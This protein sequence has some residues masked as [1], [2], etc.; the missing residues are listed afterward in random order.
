MA[1]D[2][3]KRVDLGYIAIVFIVLCA[4]A[5]CYGSAFAVP[6]FI[7]SSALFV[8]FINKLFPSLA[9]RSEMEQDRTW[10]ASI[11][12]VNS[13]VFGALFWLP[14]S[15]AGFP[16]LGIVF[17]LLASGLL[18]FFASTRMEAMATWA[19]AFAVALLGYFFGACFVSAGFAPWGIGIGC[20]AF[21]VFCH[22][23]V[24]NTVLPSSYNTAV[25]NKRDDFDLSCF[26]YKD[27][28][29]CIMFTV[30]WAYLCL[31]SSLCM[32]E[33]VIPALFHVSATSALPG[34]VFLA[35]AVVAPVV[36]YAI[37][38]MAPIF[39]VDVLQR[40]CEYAFVRC[41]IAFGCYDSAV[42]QCHWMLAR[43]VAIPNPVQEGEMTPE[44]DEFSQLIHSLP[45]G[46]K[47]TTFKESLQAYFGKDS[48]GKVNA[49]LEQEPKKRSGDRGLS[50]F[51]LCAEVQK[52]SS[53]WV[54]EVAQCYSVLVDDSD[55]GVAST[56]SS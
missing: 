40:N 25:H 50:S 51:D 2:N 9:A 18:F 48:V 1:E 54:K 49:M 47:K 14:I 28:G 36:F 3:R 11:A 23:L 21:G 53:L 39:Y 42:T 6:C 52:V 55:C 13:L 4:W 37:A 41:L 34:V 19:P 38:N 7:M 32:D 5:A 17:G 26:I 12:M 46:G 44:E 31:I 24:L 10:D 43:G 35:A 27:G 22:R 16:I 29:D 15:G 45:G 20:L 33:G 8:I 30:I 56:K